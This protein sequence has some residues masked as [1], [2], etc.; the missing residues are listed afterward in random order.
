[1]HTSTTV[2][3]N[4]Q[5]R[6]FTDDDLAVFKTVIAGLDAA[7][8]N[9]MD[10]VER[11][12]TVIA[13]FTDEGATPEEITAFAIERERAKENELAEWR[14]EQCE[15]YDWGELEQWQIEMLDSISPTWNSPE[16]RR[17]YGMPQ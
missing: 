2:L 15:A 11:N 4:G 17:G 9:G 1:V 3:P 8:Y 10:V 12:A 6:Y 13:K 16:A 14:R 7:G 5:H